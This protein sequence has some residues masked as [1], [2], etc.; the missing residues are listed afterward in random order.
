MEI[1]YSIEEGLTVDEFID[2]LKR[3]GLAARRPVDEPARIESMVA[4]ADLMV[5]ARDETGRLMCSSV[6]SARRRRRSPGG[7]F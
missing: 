2:V 7:L 6:V 5:C 4:K 3:S 1:S